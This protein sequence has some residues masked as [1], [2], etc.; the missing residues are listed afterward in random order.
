MIKYDTH[1]NL[2][3]SVPSLALTH[4]KN[5]SQLLNFSGPFIFEK[6]ALAR[7]CVRFPLNLKFFESKCSAEYD[8][9]LTAPYICTQ[10][11]LLCISSLVNSRFGLVMELYG[12]VISELKWDI[13]GTLVKAGAV[14]TSQ[15]WLDWVLSLPPIPKC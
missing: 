5:L 11:F 9:T 1:K 8:Q 13:S 14:L 7:W 3:F 10:P 6:W 15:R 4:C 12:A 2:E